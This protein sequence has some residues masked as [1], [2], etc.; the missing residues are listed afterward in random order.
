VTIL[1]LVR[2]SLVRPFTRPAYCLE[3]TLLQDAEQLRLKL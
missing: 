3:L 1:F 2:R